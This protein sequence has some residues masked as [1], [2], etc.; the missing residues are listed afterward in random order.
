MMSSG[1][2]SESYSAKHK[3]IFVLSFYFYCSKV[4]KTK[5]G[6]KPNI[7][8]FCNRTELRYSLY[9]VLGTG[10]VRSAWFSE[11]YFSS[12][13]SDG[14]TYSFA[15]FGVALAVANCECVWLLALVFLSNKY[16]ICK[17]CMRRTHKVNV[18]FQRWFDCRFC[19]MNSKRNLPTFI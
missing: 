10:F 19:A 2:I 1:K 11:V 12:E 8:K 18:K 14:E 5:I 4:I 7:T 16:V 9:T 17:K 13:V 6:D 15:I 3:P